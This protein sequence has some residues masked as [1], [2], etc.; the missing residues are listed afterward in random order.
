MRFLDVGR[1]ARMILEAREDALVTEALSRGALT[2]SS[3]E[4]PS[5]SEHDALDAA[6]ARHSARGVDNLERS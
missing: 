4:A 3:L 6:I 1:D 5:A 2:T